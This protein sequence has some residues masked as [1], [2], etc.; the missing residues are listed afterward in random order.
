MFYHFI[1]VLNDWITTI[2]LN[3]H[4]YFKFVV[5]FQ[6]E[7]MNKIPHD[8]TV[9]VR[10]R[11]KGLDLIDRVPDELQTEVRDIVQAQGS[12]SSPWKRNAKKQNAV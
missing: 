2:Q 10:N 5:L 4:I 6:L 12:R 9:E 1:S 7:F 8:Y 11:F 3:S